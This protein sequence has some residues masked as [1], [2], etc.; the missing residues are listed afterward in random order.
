MVW[1]THI[2]RIFRGKRR[3]VK[4]LNKER[5]QTSFSEISKP[6]RIMTDKNSDKNKLIIKIK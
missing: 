2:E 4:M 3:L 5:V 6:M 1:Y